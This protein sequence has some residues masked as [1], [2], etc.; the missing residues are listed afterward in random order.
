MLI[1]LINC[2]H[3]LNEYNNEEINTAKSNSQQTNINWSV[4]NIDIK[5]DKNEDINIIYNSRQKV[6]GEALLI[7][8]SKKISPDHHF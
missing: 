7:K 6:F 5:F 8:G 4:K 3:N 2:F 1:D